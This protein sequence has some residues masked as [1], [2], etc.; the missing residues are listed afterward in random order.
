MNPNVWERW[1]I[2]D[3]KPVRHLVPAFM[4]RVQ[5]LSGYFE[6][7]SAANIAQR[8]AVT[9]EKARPAAPPVV[10]RPPRGRPVRPPQTR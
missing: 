9:G 5:G 1:S 4:A 8:E 7:G 3:G 10:R 2:M 6:P